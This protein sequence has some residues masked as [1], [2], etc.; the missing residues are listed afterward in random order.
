MS[1]S[2]EQVGHIAK[3]SRLVLSAEDTLRYGQQLG[4]ILD[5]VN[6]LEKVD[7]SELEPSSHA[8]HLENQMREDDVVH[9]LTETEVFQ[10]SQ[11]Q[12]NGYFRVPQI[13]QEGS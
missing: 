2:P 11:D 4:N 7:T 6:E 10:N 13:L 1:I 3:L 5:Y 9:T 12:E 8:L